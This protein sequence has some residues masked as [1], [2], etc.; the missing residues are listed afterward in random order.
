MLPVLQRLGS[1]LRFSNCVSR[2]SQ[3][4]KCLALTAANL[5]QV[6]KCLI[7]TKQRLWQRLLLGFVNIHV[8][9]TKMLNFR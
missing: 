1:L 8:D 6:E 9:V 3:T 7:C 4:S 2:I 5:N